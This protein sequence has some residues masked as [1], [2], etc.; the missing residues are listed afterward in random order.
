MQ[1]YE[2]DDPR[3]ICKDVSNVGRWGNG[4]VEVRLQS[5]DELP[6]IMGLIRQAFVKQMGNEEIN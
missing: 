6:Y 5:S 3:G 2:I 1:F 4:D